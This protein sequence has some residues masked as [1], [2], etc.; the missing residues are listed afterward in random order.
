MKNLAF[1]SWSV[2]VF[3]LAACGGGGAPKLI[4]SGVDAP[5]LC[6]PFLKTGCQAGEKCTW[7][8]DINGTATTDEVGHIGCVPDG[9]IADGL[10]CD[11]ASQGVNGGADAC[12]GGDF[13]IG[14]TCKPI[15]DPQL[16]PGSA[17]GACGSNFACSLVHNLFDVAG[18][19]VAGI[20]QPGCDPLTQRLKT[21]T[22]NEACGSALATQPTRTCVPTSGFK[23]FAC[24]EKLSDATDGQPAL[25]ERGV[26][27]SNSCGPGFIPGFRDTSG[28]MEVLCM[29]LCAP[30]KMDKTIFTSN[31]TPANIK[32]WGD[33]SAVGKLAADA[34]PVAGHSV[35]TPDIKGSI[36]PNSKIEDCRFMWW[37]LVDDTGRL[38]NTPYNDTLG[39]CFPYTKFQFTPTGSTTKLPMVSCADLPTV[40]PGPSDPYGAAKNWGCSTSREVIAREAS[41]S[42]ARAFRLGYGDGPVVRHVFE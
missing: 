33:T 17:P 31:T 34:M 30:V 18:T 36:L 11:R 4:D 25:T 32:P 42:G 26:V 41:S 9:T 3:A 38:A 15:C 40:S 16:V 7:I 6:S 37:I 23:A 19:A 10:A 39:F 21:G 24:A 12:L 1:G 20:C 8:V 13:C 35:C 22:P 29:G 14:G 28:S 27:F 2:G 5:T